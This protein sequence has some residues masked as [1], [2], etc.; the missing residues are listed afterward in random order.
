MDRN[1][2]TLSQAFVLLS[3]CFCIAFALFLYCF[4]IVFVL[5][6]YCFRIAFALFLYC[7]AAH[8]ERVLSKYC[9]YNELRG[10]TANNISLSI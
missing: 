3:Y 1:G 7:F 8:L 10:N 9:E 5:L 6:S 4:R 2:I